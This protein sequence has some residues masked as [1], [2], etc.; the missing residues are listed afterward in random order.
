ML[1]PA[2]EES[3]RF[4]TFLTTVQRYAAEETEIE[5]VT[6]PAGAVI[7]VAIGSANRDENRWERSEEFDSFRRCSICRSGRGLECPLVRDV[8]ADQFDCAPM[9]PGQVFFG[10]VEDGPNAADTRC[11]QCSLPSIA[12]MVGPMNKPMVLS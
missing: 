12:R 6:L 10:S 7:D 3:L 1:A 5:G 2:V 4:E 11:S 8:V 9:E